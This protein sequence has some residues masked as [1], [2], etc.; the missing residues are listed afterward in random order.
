MAWITQYPGPRSAAGSNLRWPRHLRFKP[1]QASRSIPS[2]AGPP[3]FRSHSAPV[4]WGRQLRFCRGLQGQ[5]RR[6]SQTRQDALSVTIVP[7]GAA[8]GETQT[9]RD[10]LFPP[11]NSPRQGAHTQFTSTDTEAHRGTW[12]QGAGYDR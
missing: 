11:H 6:R 5:V 1:P 12:P 2:H 4:L 10:Y 8:R 9:H 7:N 3:P